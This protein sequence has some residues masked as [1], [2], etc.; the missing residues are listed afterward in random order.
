MDLL[1][2][3]VRARHVLGHSTGIADALSNLQVALIP[4][5]L[6]LQ[7]FLPKM[8]FLD[9][10]EIFSLDMDQISSNLLKKAFATWQHAFLFTSISF[11]DNFARACAEIKTWRFCFGTRKWPTSSGFFFLFLCI[12]LFTFSYLS[13]AVIDLLIYTGLVSNSKILRRHH[14]DRQILSWSSHLK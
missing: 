9:T 10:L 3:L 8:H 2:F 13:V 6:H 5:F 11:Y 4:S 12:S 7:S 14:Q 1:W